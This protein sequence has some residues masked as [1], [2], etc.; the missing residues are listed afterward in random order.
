MLN[1]LIADDEQKICQLIE[2]LIDW[3]SLDMQVIS[4]A[5]NGLEAL[6][7]I[8][9]LRPDIVITDIRMP[10]YDGLELIR[11]AKE[12]CPKTEF[13]IISGY[14]HFEYART[15]ISYGV[16]A[17]VLK[18]IRRD[19]LTDVLT[20]VSGKL[21]TSPVQPD[22]PKL[23][24]QTPDT[25]K[26]TL[27]QTFFSDLIL[28]R[29]Q[30]RLLWPVER[31]NREFHFAFSSGIFCTAVLKM[32]DHAFDGQT[33][34]CLMDDKVQSAARRLL[35]GWTTEYML[36][37]SGSFFYFLF[38][39][40]ADQK[41]HLHRQLKLLLDELRVQGEILQN[42]SVTAALGKECGELSGLEASLTHA[43]RLIE[44]RLVA[45]TGKLLEGELPDES[46]FTESPAFAEFSPKFTQ[47]LEGLE[48]FPVR[49]ALL[50][51]K[52]QMLAR[53][54]LSGHAFYETGKEIISLYQ[55]SMKNYCIRIEE[56]FSQNV[57]SGAEN[58]ASAPELFDYLIRQ[59]TTSYEKAAK[60]KRQDE[61]RPVRVAKQFVLAHY[62]ESL[63][64]EQVSA[65]AELSPAYLGTVFK[66]ETG[67]TFLE[68]L[69]GVRMDA[70]KQLLK[71]T[72]RTVAD[73]CAAVGY[74]DVRYFTKTFT[75]YS[76][77]KPNEYR[78]LYS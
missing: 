41:S 21:K 63:T 17:Y 15:A 16:N 46:R 57:L 61:N 75:K 9:T 43:R 68:Y 59:I 65:Q 12:S 35:G 77:L 66:K 11:L 40:H 24:P 37:S 22:Q 2:K 74:N 10:G 6:E 34:L 76:G 42:F 25:D 60:Q 67:M 19:E 29:S 69:S 52:N 14:R 53:K 45:G 26:E 72:N 58:C 1:V 31:I 32:D 51:L 48:V 70:A 23:H 78:K 62:S 55:F 38:Q 30:E 71:E 27:R 73:I 4:T 44:E 5:H 64:L 18:P 56:T 39:I 3:H 8:R 54:E 13:I 49:D 7:Q 47:A 50:R 33:H 36:T 28:H 20:R